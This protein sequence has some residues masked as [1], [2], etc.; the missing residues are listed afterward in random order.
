[1]GQFSAKRVTTSSFTGTT[2]PILLVKEKKPQH[3]AD[4]S[5]SCLFCQGLHAPVIWLPWTH[6]LPHLPDVGLHVKITQCNSGN[7]PVWVVSALWLPTAVT[8]QATF[9]Q[10]T[11][12]RA[13]R[14]LLL[15]QMLTNVPPPVAGSACHGLLC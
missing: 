14:A 15:L 1:M 4:P 12:L 6:H 13:G 9:T 11:P 8:A 7:P 5:E 10:P 2:N 3:P